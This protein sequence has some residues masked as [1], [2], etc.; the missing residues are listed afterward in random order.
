MRRR[1]ITELAKEYAK[2]ESEVKNNLEDS[3]IITPYVTRN[4][5]NR[6]VI[7][8]SKINIEE[9]IFLDYYKL[10]L[11]RYCNLKFPNRS[12]IMAE[13]MNIVPD[14]HRYH[15]YTIYKFDFK[16]FFN[17]VS[18][19]KSFAYICETLNLKT[20]EYEFLKKYTSVDRKLIPGIGLH[21]T[22]VEII[23]ERFN[24]EIK[25]IFKE[26]CIYYARYVDDCILILDEK[27]DEDKIEKVIFKLM[28]QCFGDKVKINDTKTDYYNSSCV[29]SKFDYLGY[30]FKKG[31]NPKS[32]FK[33]GIA[34]N[35]LEKYTK[36]INDIVLE[37]KVTNNIEILSFKL[38]LLFK[39][40]VY[41]GARKNSNKYRWQVRGISDSYKELKRFMK[42]SKDFSKITK[43]TE[44][45]FTRTVERSF[46]RNRVN[47]PAKIKNQIKNN[48]FTSC[49]LNNKTLL[50]H[51]KIGLK[52]NTL[53]QR[54]YIVDNSNLESC[55]YSEL[56][57]KLLSNI[58]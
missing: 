37:Y 54:L 17:T 1:I 52:H 29:N 49:F 2:E 6:V 7:D 21:N 25:K 22:L 57:N 8:K 47:F 18:S 30:E 39:R 20:F 33:F 38:E 4:V 19:K 53:K 43:D 24:L 12:Y 11:N 42:N 50:L 27:I 13:I 9:Q 31:Q 32:E 10:L 36:I 41:Y 34:Q 26:S 48:K 46:T 14:L 3:V 23:G 5:K 40:V 15:A 28:K 56:A 55:S 58:K 45:F 35:K 51:Q 44:N 16:D